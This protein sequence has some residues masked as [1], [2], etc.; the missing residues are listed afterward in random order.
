MARRTRS[1]EKQ[2]IDMNVRAG[3]QDPETQD[4]ALR[5]RMAEVLS[6]LSRRVSRAADVGKGISLDADEPDLLTMHGGLAAINEAATKALVQ[7]ATERVTRR[8]A[9]EVAEG[10]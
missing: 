4:E 3:R 9:S 8:L 6:D 5:R 1:I 7:L 2:V 10:L